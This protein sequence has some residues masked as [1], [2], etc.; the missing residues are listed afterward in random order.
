MSRSPKQAFFQRRL[1]NDQWV[2][3]KVFN[4]TNHYQ[5]TKDDKYEQGCA[6][7]GTLI[8]CWW[9]HKLV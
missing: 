9:G 1:T 5:I 3:K 4:I 2:Y 6:V 7:K 8:H